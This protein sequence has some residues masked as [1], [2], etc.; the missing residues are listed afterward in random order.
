MKKLKNVTLLICIFTCVHI[1][2]Q[3]SLESAVHKQSAAKDFGY[4][5]KG[6][7]HFYK[8]PLK[9]KKKQWLQLGLVAG[10][11][12]ALTFADEDLNPEFRAIENDVPKTVRVF[13][14]AYGGP[15]GAVLISSGLYTYGYFSK[16]TKIKKAGILLMS[17]IAAGGFLQSSIKTIVGR[18]RP[19]TEGATPGS[20]KPFSPLAAYHSFPSG[21]SMVAAIF[22]H[23]LASQIDNTWA[24][25][26]LYSLGAITPVSR[27]LNGAHWFSDVALGTFFGFITVNSID[28]YL[29]GVY[30]QEEQQKLTNTWKLSTGITN[31]KVSYTF[32]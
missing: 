30:E 25:V 23:S 22:T 28:R 11:Y 1:Q 20:Y 13:G 16:K 9:W 15:F 8:A 7:V 18:A 5:W 3:H 6:I 26:G 10:T 14:D 32:N 31:F 19:G 17:S 21:H 24:K 4:T 27:L 12:T 29:S 2:A